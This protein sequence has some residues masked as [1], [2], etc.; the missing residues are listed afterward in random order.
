[1]T[2]VSEQQLTGE[3]I[4]S[5]TR[6]FT[7]SEAKSAERSLSH[8]MLITGEW[9]DELNARDEHIRRID[10]VHTLEG[11]FDARPTVTLM[12]RVNDDR[13]AVHWL[14]SEDQA[15]VL[16]TNR[17]DLILADGT[18][19]DH[20][21]LYTCHVCCSSPSPP[22]SSSPSSCHK[23]SSFIYLVRYSLFVLALSN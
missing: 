16:S 10:S 11:L 13:C 4:S 2:C 20:V 17:T 15:L 9:R 14:D 7:V 1:M 22:S 8:G 12:C 21:G 3:V 19:D 5:C 18:F 23:L 6:L